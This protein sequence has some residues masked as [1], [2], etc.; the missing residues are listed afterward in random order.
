M[1]Y[2]SQK[3]GSSLELPCVQEL[4][5]KPL[6]TVPSRYVRRD[7]D[8]PVVPDTDSVPQ[9]PLIDMDRLSSQEFKNLE[10][11]NLHQACK[12]WGFFQLI[13]HGVSGSL[14]EK[15]KMEIQEFFDLPMDEKKKYWQK[16]GEMEGFRQAFVMSEEQKLDWADA[17]CMI[18]LPRNLRKPYLF[19]KLPLPFRDLLEAYLGE[20]ENLALKILSLMETVLEMETEELKD[21]FKEGYQQMRMNYYPP[22]PQPEL[23]MGLNH[24]TDVGGLT[25]VLQVNEV[26]GL[27]I[28]KDGKW[29]P[30]KPFPDAFIINLGDM[31][32]IVTNGIYK[33]TEHRATVNLVKERISVATFH[34]PRLDREI[35]PATS[36][37]SSERPALFRRT[38]VADIFGAFSSRRLNGRTNLDFMRIQKHEPKEK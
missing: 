25:I 31:L 37:L 1:D 21:I 9:V 7:Q 14:L 24:H 26:E 34:S 15:V 33:S 17:F 5:K 27:Q 38:S 20:L 30:I 18:T 11:E 6:I 10:L 16:P 13:N 19:P 29:I 35:G 32:E 36:L 22:C 4:V 3:F 8:S 2:E 12:D 28:K 23:V